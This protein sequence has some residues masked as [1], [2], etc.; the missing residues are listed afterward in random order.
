MPLCV[1][2]Y[3]YYNKNIIQRYELL[4][5]TQENFAIA[6]NKNLYVLTICRPFKELTSP[7]VKKLLGVKLLSKENRGYATCEN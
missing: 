1:S 5:E 6:A 2:K 4:A 3:A 7:S